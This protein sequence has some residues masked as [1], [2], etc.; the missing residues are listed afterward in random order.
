[1]LTAALLQAAT[2]FTFT[3]K[4]AV[5]S[6]T[7]LGVST[8]A[9]DRAAAAAAME[10]ESM[11]TSNAGSIG[12]KLEEIMETGG[13]PFPLSMVVGQDA[14]KQALLL[15]AVNNRMVGYLCYVMFVWFDLCFVVMKI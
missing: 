4:A 2:G 5:H 14:I 15:S 8:D 1:M 10:A 3:R 13:R 11:G 12:V 7:A 9:A 6:S